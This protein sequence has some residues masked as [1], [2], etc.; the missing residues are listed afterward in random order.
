MQTYQGT[1]TV[2]GGKIV[3]SNVVQTGGPAAAWAKPP[4]LIRWQMAFVRHV[5][6]HG[7]EPSG[8]VGHEASARAWARSRRASQEPSLCSP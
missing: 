2:T 8:F 7:R 6:P 5:R 4:H 3:A 1:D